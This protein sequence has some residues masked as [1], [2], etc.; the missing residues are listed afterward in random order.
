MQTDYSGP[1]LFDD[2][3]E[4][5]AKAS[6]A[7]FE[8]SR[9]KSVTRCVTLRYSP[10]SRCLRLPAAADLSTHACITDLTA[11]ILGAYT[12][13]H[14]CAQQCDP[15]PQHGPL[16][17]GKHIMLMKGSPVVPTHSS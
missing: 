9:E 1:G 11:T 13:C 16:H 6:T 12:A 5:F 10:L 2:P 4:G 8:Y 14:G 17:C 15:L 3:E 7:L